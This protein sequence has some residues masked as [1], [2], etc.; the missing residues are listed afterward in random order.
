VAVVAEVGQSVGT[1]LEEETIVE[2]RG[3]TKAETTGGIK[4]EKKDST[5]EMTRKDGFA[6]KR[7][8]L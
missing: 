2:K 7:S 8:R 6:R 4:T 1:R 5:R 3:T